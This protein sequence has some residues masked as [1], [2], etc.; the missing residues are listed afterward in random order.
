MEPLDDVTGIVVEM[1]DI[2]RDQAEELDRI[3]TQ[4][5]QVIGRIPE[6]YRF[7][8]IDS[9]LSALKVRAREVSRNLNAS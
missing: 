9:K 5:E 1:I 8:A 7:S 4:I 3:F 2:L 6:V